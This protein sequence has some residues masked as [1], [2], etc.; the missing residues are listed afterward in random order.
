MTTNAFVLITSQ[1]VV[2][3]TI[4]AVRSLEAVGAL[5]K[6][7][8]YVLC[9]DADAHKTIER[10]MPSERVKP[11]RLDDIPAVRAFADRPISHFAFACKPYLLQWALNEGG[12]EKALYFDSDIWFVADPSFLFGE[13]D[14]HDI[15]LVPYILSPAATIK[16]WSDVVRNAQRTGYYNG[17]FVGCS[18][19]ATEFLDWWADRCAYG[20]FRD[21]YQGVDGDQKYLNWVPSLF[22]NVRVMRHRGLN[23]KPWN[24]RYF[25]VQRAED[26][27]ATLGGDPVVF[28]HFSQNLGNLLTWPEAF[29][30]EVSRYLDEVERARQDAGQPYVDM[31]HRDT[32]DLTRPLL[33]REGKQALVLGLMRS[34]RRPFDAVSAT[35]RVAVARGARRLPTS[36]QQ[37]LARRYLGRWHLPGD[38]PVESFGALVEHLP[39]ADQAG[40]VVFAGI[41]RLA[42]F[43]VYLGYPVSVYEPFQGYSN[44]MLK[45]LFNPQWP[46][47]QAMSDLLK[48]EHALKLHRMPVSEASNEAAPV[49]AVVAAR[50]APDDVAGVLGTLAEKPSLQ[51]LVVVFDPG[52]PQSY[53]EQVRAAVLKALG[54]RAGEVA[55]L[56][57]FDVVGVKPVQGGA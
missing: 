42:V 27:A 44:P 23:I 41:S 37:W 8:C 43:L 30:P 35:M 52:W 54:A 10:T 11:L 47:A 28:F 2:A 46:A 17:G 33:P 3:R 21:F 15:L 16:D 29:Y 7:T 26:G 38:A 57:G 22:S 40:P 5:A 19:R 6:T 39:P 56:N 34:Y 51:R 14:A 32:G 1:A 25:D 36:A 45:M 12:A 13:L 48:G 49:V 55:Q 31:T 9:L 20:T 4:A 50:R 24:T 53:H 18:Q